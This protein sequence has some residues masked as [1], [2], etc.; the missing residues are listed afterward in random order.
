M[1]KFFQNIILWIYLKLHT[2]GIALGIALFNTETEILRADPIDGNE[3]NNHTQRMRSRNQLLEK[4]YAGKTDEK[5]RHIK[6]LLLLINTVR[7][8]V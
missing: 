3:R 5:Q 7:V 2:F 8:T 4:F 6:W 1:R